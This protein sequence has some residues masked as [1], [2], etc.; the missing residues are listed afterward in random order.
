M[1]VVLRAQHQVREVD[2]PRVRRNVRTFRHEA[3][4]TEVTVIH[5]VPVHLL[6]DAI[7]LERVARVD[8][9]EQRGEGIAEAEAAPASMA[10]VEDTRELALERSRIVELRASP[11]ERMTRGSLHA[12]LAYSG[13]SRAHAGGI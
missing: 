3:H 11:I 2:V 6:V 7:E 9:I 5:D 1:L 12:S 13:F 10:D 4:V 8:R